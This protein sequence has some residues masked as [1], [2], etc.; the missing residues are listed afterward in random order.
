[1]LEDFGDTWLSTSI[2][3]RQQM[4]LR[5]GRA[6]WEMPAPAAMSLATADG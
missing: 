3:R 1:M 5:L 2:E 4:L 6:T